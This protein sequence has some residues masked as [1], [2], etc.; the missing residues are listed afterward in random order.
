MAIVLVVLK[1]KH[2]LMGHPFT[3]FIDQLSLK[4][5]FE[6][7]QLPPINQKWL[8]KILV[9]DFSIKYKTGAENKVANVL[10]CIPSPALMQIIINFLIN[11]IDH[12]NFQLISLQIIT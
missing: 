1:Y 5:L 3:I 12:S 7:R 9:F 11:E 10:S 2:Y 4:F 6:H 8:V